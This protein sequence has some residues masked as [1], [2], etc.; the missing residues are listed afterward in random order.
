MDDL[1]VTCDV[2]PSSAS[3]PPAAQIPV[4]RPHQQRL[5]LFASKSFR[6]CFP[7]IS[8]NC[9]NELQHAPLLQ[10]AYVEVKWF[11]AVQFPTNIWTR[12]DAYVKN[13]ATVF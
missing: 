7:F 4:P 3:L 9:K 13:A 10:V 6:F 8:L 2:F 12:L 5:P 1:N 11:V